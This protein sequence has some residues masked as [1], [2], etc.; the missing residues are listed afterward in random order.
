MVLSGSRLSRAV[1]GGETVRMFASFEASV[2][3]ATQAQIIGALV[4]VRAR[5]C[6]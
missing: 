2:L 3:R 5:N 4:G 6:E 1:T